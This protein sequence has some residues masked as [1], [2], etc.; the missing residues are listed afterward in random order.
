M[1]STLMTA[2][3]P[4]MAALTQA[5]YGFVAR[6]PIRRVVDGEG[7]CILALAFQKIPTE[8]QDPLIDPLAEPLIHRTAAERIQDCYAPFFEFFN[9]KA[10]NVN[11]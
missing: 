9:L 3:S 8:S 11:K 6:W 5:P 10:F 7:G 1:L 4:D 2:T